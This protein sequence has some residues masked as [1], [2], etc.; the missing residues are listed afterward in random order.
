[1]PMWRVDVA[2]E[3]AIGISGTCNQVHVYFDD[4]AREDDSYLVIRVY[5]IPVRSSR[6]YAFAYYIVRPT[7]VSHFRPV[8]WIIQYYR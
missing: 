4:I 1:M 3:L 6:R 5:T 8:P 7:E 2:N